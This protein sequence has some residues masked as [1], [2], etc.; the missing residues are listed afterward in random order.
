MC[1][2]NMKE[3]CRPIIESF[4]INKEPVFYLKDMVHP[5]MVKMGHKMV[6]NDVI[7]EPG[8]NTFIVTG[9]NMGGKSTLLR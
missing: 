9:P 3:Y 2:Y 8:V 5:C 7:F 1:T 6:G 4:D